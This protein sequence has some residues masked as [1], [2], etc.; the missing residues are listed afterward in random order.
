MLRFPVLH[1]IVLIVVALISACSPGGSDAEIAVDSPWVR[2]T[3]P[4]RTVA[5]GYLELR[6]NGATERAL[7]RAE[8]P[9]AS[10]VEIHTMTHEDG[11]MRMRQ[12]D[13]L[14]VPAGSTVSL[15]PGGLHLMLFDIETAQAGNHVPVTLTFDDGWEIEARFPVRRPE[16]GHQH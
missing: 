9:D 8:S 6:N 15:E 7:V 10:R 11:M 5:A 2:E 14:E 1:F 16:V 13:R 4:G 12:I 3:P